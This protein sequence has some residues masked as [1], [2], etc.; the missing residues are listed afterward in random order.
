MK[1]VVKGI[2]VIIVGLINLFFSRLVWKI[3]TL[4]IRETSKGFEIKSLTP[5]EVNIILNRLVGVVLIVIGLL[6]L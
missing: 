4:A 2:L 6:L 5:T 3:Y 1:R